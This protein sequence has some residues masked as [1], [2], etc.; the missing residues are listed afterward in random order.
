M[1][2][3]RN[4]LAVGLA[5][6]A[7]VAACSSQHGPSSGTASN[8]NTNVGSTVGAQGDVGSVKMA[9][10]VANGINVT[11]LSYTITGNGQSYA[12]I[13]PIGDAQ[14]AEVV[15]GGI[16]AG[17]GYTLNVTGTDSN[18]DPCSGTAGTFCVTPGQTTYEVLG[19]VCLQPTDG[20]VAADVGNGSVAIEAGIT[21]TPTGPFSCPGINSFSIAPAEVLGSQLANLSIATVGPVNAISWTTTACNGTGTASGF[22]GAD[23]GADSTDPNV[24]FNCGSCTGQVTVTATALNNEV[25]PGADAATNVCA[26][27]KFTT[28]SG[29]INC[30]GGGTKTC[31]APTPNA[32][33]TN[34]VNFAGDTSNCGGCGIKCVAG[35]S[36]SS[37]MCVAKVC[38]AGQALCPDGVTCIADQ[39]DVN[40]CGG[41]GPGQ[42][43]GSASFVCPAGD[44]CTA[45]VCGVPPP[46]PC[47]GGVSPNNTPI[48]CVPCDGNSGT[49]APAG[50]CTST[51]QLLVT[52]DIAAGNITGHTLKPYVAS[53]KTGSC[54]ECMVFNDCIDNDTNGDTGKECADVTAPTLDGEPGPAECIDTLKCIYSTLCDTANPP[55]S[56]FC[57]TA[58]GSACLTAGAANGPC[59]NDEID[60][61]G[62]GSCSTMF[63]AAK[64]CTEGDPTASSKAYVNQTLP[65]GN[66]NA[67]TGCAVANCKTL[68]TP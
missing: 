62:V 38:A 28:F 8:Q 49:T 14:S 32:C 3:I 48:G 60:G 63:P 25:Q 5:A 11:S 44:A 34:C 7:S 13:M 15:A 53:T 39:T 51:E 33:G 24:G 2:F 56:C 40:N 21:V 36:C 45:G 46:V 50:V 64:S 18:N 65:A 47:T 31:F 55:S 41:C 43:G 59:L 67:L 9:W 68:C 58:S 57:G 29:L 10:Q 52:R 23:G 26:G 66:A 17:C 6:A 20:Q 54:Y 35:D 22:V 61:L 37:G 30:E 4:A 1:K 12:G 27:A 19:V 42:G 16:L